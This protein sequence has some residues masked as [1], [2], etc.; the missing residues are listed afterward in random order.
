[1]LF[2]MQFA[3]RADVITD[4]NNAA[5][6]AIR[7]EKTPPPRASRYLA[8][9]H[10]A[11]YD[12]INGISRTHE[13]YLVP[14][15][16][17]ASA[18]QEAAASA[19]AHR[20]LLTFYPAFS[21]TFNTLHTETLAQIRNGKKKSRGVSWG[22][23]TA[24]QVLAWRA[25]DGADATISP[26]I[27]SGAGAWTPT[28]P[29]FAAYL[30]PQWGHV[31]P[32]VMTN[33]EQFRPPPPAA[34]DSAEYA[35]DYNEVIA[36][37]A[38]TNSSRTDD[39]SQ[40]AL[41]WSDG[42]GTATPPGHWNVIAQ[43]VSAELG[44]SLQE[45]ARLFALLNIAMADAAICAW[46]AK[47]SYNFWRPITAIRNGDSDGNPAT[48]ADSSWDSFIITPPFPDY[49]SGHSTFSGAASTVLALF[50]GTDDVPFTSSSDF[51]RGVF[52]SFSSFS[53]AAD[54]AAV[55]R[56]YGGIH[57]RAA[58]AAGLQSGINIGTFTFENYLNP[59]RNRGR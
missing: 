54:E 56:L 57:F 8:I 30:L 22:E 37:G 9:L 27:G 50:F 43:S 29:V 10:L 31:T 15:R 5:L 51:L 7:A 32:F 24:A 46:D 47:Y 58:N 26:P 6:D 12:A 38:G 40:I 11:I 1:M 35:A 44:S 19:A 18:S 36:L 2:T 53:A 39:Q 28:P 4:W 3:V 55:S 34:L 59:K 16:G 52:R 42:G 49:V 25:N 17:P 45:R 48:A 13:A 23:F 14:S 21:G 20:V 33:H 41:F